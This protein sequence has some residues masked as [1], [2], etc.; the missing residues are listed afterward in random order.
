MVGHHLGTGR[1]IPQMPLHFQV[2]NQIQ[3]AVQIGMDQAAHF[4][5]SH[6]RRPFSSGRSV[7][8]A[9]ARV[10]GPGETSPCPRGCRRRRQF[11]CKTILPTPAERSPA[12]SVRGRV[13]LATDH[14]SQWG[15]RTKFHTSDAAM[16]FLEKC[17][18]R[19]GL[20]LTALQ[21]GWV[22]NSSSLVDVDKFDQQNP[23]HRCPV[24]DNKR[25]SPHATIAF[26]VF[27]YDAIPKASRTRTQPTIFILTE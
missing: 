10:P 19:M 25:E 21:M 26:F 17:G 15:S 16:L 1:T 9:S 27:H 8:A 20:R 7:V 13:R 24:I 12:R 22:F 11:P 3:L 2:A 6:V 14:L 5:T 18:D 4:L 23:V